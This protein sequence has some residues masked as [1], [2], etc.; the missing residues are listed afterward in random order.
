MTVSPTL[1]PLVHCSDSGR[2][3]DVCFTPSPNFDER[4]DNEEVSVLVIHAISLPPGCYHNRYV[5]DLFTNCLA[6]GAHPYFEQI[7]ELAVSAHFYIERE[8]RLI[9]FVPTHRRAWHAGQSVFRGCPRVN[10]F[11]IGVELAGSDH[12]EFESAQ[13]ITLARLTRCLQSAYPKI[14]VE[15]I[16]GHS[17]IAPGRKTDPGPNFNWEHYRELLV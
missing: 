12:D 14:T 10:D 7:A 16:V 5:E 3:Q 2:V 4:P 6:P 11:S 15:N 1:P 9:Q 13:Y 17:D 8:G